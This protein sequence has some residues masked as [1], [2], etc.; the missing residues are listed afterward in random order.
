MAYVGLH[1]HTTYSLLEWLGVIK[2]HISYAQQQWHDTIAITDYHGTYGLMDMY[3]KSKE[4]WL[5][6][7]L[8]VDMPWVR[9]VSQPIRDRWYITFLAKSVKGYH[10]LLE[11]VSAAYMRTDS[12]ATPYV[13]MDLL[14]QYH[15]DLIVFWG[16]ESSR[17]GQAVLR[18][19]TMSIYD[20]MAR[21]IVDIVG[22][23]SVF[24][25][26]IAQDYTKLPQTRKVNEAVLSLS[27]E[28]GLGVFVSN[29]V[30]YASPDDKQAYETALAIKDNKKIY[31]DDRRKVPGDHHIVNE[32]WIR[33]TLQKNG[34]DDATITPWIE[35]TQAIADM[36]DISIDMGET[37]FPRYEVSEEVKALYE[38]E[39]DSLVVG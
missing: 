5:K 15:D 1:H 14:R 19:E 27:R 2:R 23:D 31:E 25:E 32:V 4:A 26:V 8:G 35:Q 12:G 11:L 37:L 24:G 18:G 10:T 7:L 16:G 17:Y 34:Y 33:A 9:D 30:H 21:M 29:D 20:D 38:K 36:I 39:K 6:P 13:D 22:Q 3:K 28:L